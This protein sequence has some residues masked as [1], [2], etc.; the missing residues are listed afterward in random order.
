[1]RLKKK[2]NLNRF[3]SLKAIAHIVRCIFRH[4][5]KTWPILTKACNGASLTV[6]D[7]PGLVTEDMAWYNK[8][9]LP[10]K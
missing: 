8:A 5:N 4:G 10:T 6:R 1:M 3:S 7:A 2:K 9:V